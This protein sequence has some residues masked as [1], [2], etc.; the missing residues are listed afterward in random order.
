MHT[1]LI[2][3]AC[4]L[5][6]LFKYFLG[7]TQTDAT[8]REVQHIHSH[9]THLHGHVSL[10]SPARLKS[11]HAAFNVLARKAKQLIT[12]WAVHLLVKAECTVQLLRVC[13]TGCEVAES[14]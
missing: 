2:S 7:I 10:L 11:R 3:C 13:E 1:Q 6:N 9:S 5:L 8:H 4:Q 12:V 14:V